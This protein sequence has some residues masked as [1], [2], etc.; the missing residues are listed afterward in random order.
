MLGCQL[1]VAPTLLGLLGR[2]YESTFFGHDL[3]R[4]PDAGS[5]VLLHHNRSVGIYSD[6]R[7]VVFS[8]NRQVEYYSGD[9]KAGQMQRVPKADARMKVL[10]RDATALFQVG[11]TLY[12]DRRF[13]I[14][15]P[16]P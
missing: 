3:L 16:A 6:E 15:P 12:M 9:P 13:R 10:E 2:P 1:D 4:E 7:L 8:L 14:L 5:R 11:D